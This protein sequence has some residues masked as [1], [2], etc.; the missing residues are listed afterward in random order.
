ME[1]RKREYLV[2]RICAGYIRYKIK[3]GDCLI[4]KPLTVHQNYELQEIYLEAYDRAFEDNLLTDEEV[5]EMMKK[6]GFWNDMDERRLE[7]IPK[8]IEN[9]KV[10]MFESYFNSENRETL[11]GFLRKAEEQL[12]TTMYKRHRYSSSTCEGYASYYKWNWMIEN[13]TYYENGEKY[14]W[15]YDSISDVL[16]HY[17]DQS[18]SEYE[19]R[20]LARTDPWRS[21]W[22]AGKKLG[23]IFDKP[24][25]EFTLEQKTLLS[26]SSLYDSVSDSSEAPSDE[27]IEDDDI[28]DGW[29]I[30]QRRKRENQ[31]T[32]SSVE[33]SIS[34]EKI[35]NS[36]EVFLV[37]GNKSEDIDRISS[38]NN[39]HIAAAKKSRFT[40]LEKTDGAIQQGDLPDVKHE[41]QLEARNQYRDTIKGK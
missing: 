32:Q 24:A 4:I 11:R 20:Q 41:L 10:K 35:A 8:D 1:Q 31:T 26:W 27:V 36:G 14:D 9:T 7:Q 18:I 2:A 33:G 17:Q 15:V 21:I 6:N 39:P 22:N 3:S 37:T 40:A 38:M 16:S 28:L 5:V 25:A 30:S 19:F 29:L 13:C 12:T 34:N 23:S